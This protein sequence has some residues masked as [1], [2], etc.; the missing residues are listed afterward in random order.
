MEELDNDM[1]QIKK[2]ELGSNDKTIN[3]KKY[4]FLTFKS[5]V[6]VLVNILIC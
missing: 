1:T 4:Q 5:A 3:Y 6:T 2:C